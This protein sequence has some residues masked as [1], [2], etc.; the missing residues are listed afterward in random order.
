M[1]LTLK[2]KLIGSFIIVALIFGIATVYSFTSMK[3][4]V[5][6]YDYLVGSVTELESITQAIH[7]EIALEVSYYRAHMLYGDEEQIEKFNESAANINKYIQTARDLSEI[8]ET[9]QRL[10]TIEA[11]QSQLVNTAYP[12]MEDVKTDREKAIATGLDEIVPITSDLETEIVSMNQWL[13]DMAKDIEVETQKEAA[14]SVTLIFSISL[15]AAII[16]MIIGFILS[17]KISKPINLVVDQMNAVANG[18]L[19]QEKLKITS[20]DE[21]GNLINA[22][23]EMSDKLHEILRKINTV[24]HTVHSHSEELT[25]SAKEVS[26][27][28]EQV[29]MTMEEL[30]SGAETQANHS[31]EISST[32]ADF[33]HKVQDANAD[34]ECVQENSQKVIEMTHTGS[35]LMQGSMKQ[36]KTI[37]EIVKSSVENVQNLQSSSQEIYK[38]VVVIK[39]I[40]EQTNLLALNAAIEAARAGEHGR[41]F[42]VVA[43]EV[44]KLAEQTGASVSEIN[45]IVEN[46]QAGFGTVTQSLQEGYKEVEKGTVQI[47]TTGQTFEEISKQVNDMV[48]SVKNI[49]DA[50]TDI[51][52]TSQEMNSSI[53]EVAATAEE[54]AAGIE[55]TSASAQQAN[56]TLEQV[57]ESS[58]QLAQLAEELNDLV[59]QF[60]LEK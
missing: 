19:S 38:L 22:T 58:N 18:D 48:S 51:A 47:E 16:A 46:I 54:S 39:D 43:E 53:Q 55:E 23:N 3:K 6:S 37:D 45:N 35:Q 32:M 36:M 2:R 49:T 26:A 34:G 14:S 44:R 9:D 11:L 29:T 33:V 59:S 15:L 12:I 31:S 40:A 27:G 60:K 50:L 25:Q 20:K 52:S 21:I 41:G 4:V 17:L 42:S 13:H 56:A 5:D 8:P 57:A 10:A 7:T 1:K 28:A 30:A 24:S